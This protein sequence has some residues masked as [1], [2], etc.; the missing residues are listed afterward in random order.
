MSAS[1]VLQR[2]PGEGR[3]P[4]AEQK[5]AGAALHYFDLRDWAP[6]FAGEAISVAVEL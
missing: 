4:V 1:S 6:A 5:I 2:F 3:G